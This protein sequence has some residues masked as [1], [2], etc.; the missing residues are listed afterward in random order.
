MSTRE[1]IYR[2]IAF[3]TDEQIEELA[4]FVKQIKNRQTADEVDALCGIFH[5]ATNPDLIPLEKTAWEQAAAENEKTFRE[6]YS[7]ENA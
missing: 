1:V 4:I 2:D 5:D 3:F 6:S 7:D